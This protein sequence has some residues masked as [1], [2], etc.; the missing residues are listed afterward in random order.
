M[1]ETTPGLRAGRRRSPAPW[2]LIGMI[3]LVVA[4][5]RFVDRGA[6]DF[7]D[8]DDWAY[9]QTARAA[10]GEAGRCDV[11]CFGDSLMKLGVVPRAV[12]DRSGRRV[13]N[14]AVS[15]GQA[16][17]SYALLRRAIGAGARPAAVVVDFAPMLLR[18]GPRHNLSRWASLLG[19]AEAAELAWSAR[20]ADLFATVALGRVLPSFRSRVG[21]RTNLMGALAGRDASHRWG[22]SVFFR[23]WRANDG[24]QLAPAS[25]A[26]RDLDGA[27]V[28]AFR[29]AFYPQWV[30]D[31]ANEEAIGKFLALAAGQGVRVYWVLTP[32]WPALNDRLARDG[33]GAAHEAF[34]R[35]WQS[36]FPDHLTVVDGRG[37]VSDPAGFYDMNHLSIAGAYAFSLALGDVL[38]HTLPGAAGGPDSSPSRWV[39]LPACRLRPVPEGVEDL[40]RS[41]VAVQPK[42]PLRR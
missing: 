37:V 39:A 2:G 24:A 12:G 8:V 23:N 31:P 30:C 5:E 27:K 32:I 29:A 6:L 11:L 7:L 40:R 3:A 36:R 41:L 21:V 17:A 14:L 42:D 26:M 4:A 25:P 15:G 22:N 18:V 10:A 34:A 19:P 28:D 38:R 33:Q 16:P 13:Y 35:S 1:A 9:R 20:D